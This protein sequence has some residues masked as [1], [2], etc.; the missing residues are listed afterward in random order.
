[1]A[2]GVALALSATLL[3]GPGGL[4]PR[5]ACA[6]TTAQD[7]LAPPDVG[8]AQSWVT[9]QA[10]V[11]DAREKEA[12]ERYCGKVQQ[13]LGVQFAVVIVETFSSAREH[14][15]AASRARA[16][17]EAVDG[18]Y[19]KDGE[20]AAHIVA[21]LVSP[22][23]VVLVMGAGDVRPVGERLLELLRTPV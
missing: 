19:A 5:L 21:E 12:I 15:A 20:E 17:A 10:G 16:L 18:R 14:A 3:S 11:L 2:V 8:R 1:M 13:A 22:G 4:A 6:Q 7:S 9:D 23:D